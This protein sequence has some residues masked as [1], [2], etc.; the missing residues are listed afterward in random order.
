[1][2]HHITYDIIYPIWRYRLWPNRT[3][4][5]TG[6]SAMKY[7]GEYDIKNMDY[8][9]TFLAYFFD[10]Q[11]VGVNSGH[12]CSDNGYRS[13]GLYVFPEYR[14]RGIG[15]ELLK[16]TIKLGKTTGCTYVWSYPKNSSWKTYSK[17]GF[18]LSTDWEKSENGMNAY[19]IY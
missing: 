3:S 11:I 8:V 6:T 19:C 16:E 13:R 17:A 1:M 9:P 7:L 14:G 10:N 4:D 18:N 12:K 15:V 5:I 2:I